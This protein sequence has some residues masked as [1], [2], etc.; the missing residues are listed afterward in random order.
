MKKIIII[1]ISILLLVFVSCKN[2]E[3]VSKEKQETKD[4]KIEEVEENAIE[5]LVSDYNENGENRNLD[6]ND[7]EIDEIPN[8]I[9]ISYYIDNELY[10]EE[11]HNKEETIE[12]INLSS[13]YS[14][15]KGWVLEYD[16]TRYFNRITTNVDL[17]FYFYTL[18]EIKNLEYI[19]RHL[20]NAGDVIELEFESPLDEMYRK[21]I[22]VKNYN[23][24][25][26]VLLENGNILV[27]AYGGRQS[28]TIK[29]YN[30]DNKLIRTYGPYSVLTMGSTINQFGPFHLIEGEAYYKNKDVLVGDVISLHI[31]EDLPDGYTY[32]ERCDFRNSEK[33]GEH[34]YRLTEEGFCNYQVIVYDEN[35]I[36]VAASTFIQVYAH[37]PDHYQSY[38]GEAM[39]EVGI[40]G[41]ESYYVLKSGYVGTA[42]KNGDK[43][44][45][46]L[47]IIKD[48]KRVESNYEIWSVKYEIIHNGNNY[49]IEIVDGVIVCDQELLTDVIIEVTVEYS[50]GPNT[51]TI[52]KQIGT[53]ASLAPL[54]IM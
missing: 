19:T 27:N 23:Q 21:E 12:L 13:D 14:Y 11:T 47:Y 7:K 29:I 43:I 53:D 50:Y 54:P 9:T 4:E 26:L 34:E 35:E 46:K 48:G 24:E 22:E 10:K 33:I 38:S 52:V 31:L 1:F 40:E 20:F 44:D 17:S 3:N 41:G 15:F 51:N 39:L 30:Q 32:F 6:K 8:T 5:E 42:F 45:T 36:L 28:F 37:R 16:P 49:D 2:G 25:T 18:P